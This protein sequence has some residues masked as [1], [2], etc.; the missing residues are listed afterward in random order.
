MQ[1]QSIVS[2]Q[3]PYQG[4]I[5]TVLDTAQAILVSTEQTGFSSAAINHFPRE[6]VFVIFVYVCAFC[7]IILCAW[8]ISLIFVAI[9]IGGEQI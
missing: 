2:R 4:H 7:C 5:I 1:R 6:C 9:S 3:S 8:F